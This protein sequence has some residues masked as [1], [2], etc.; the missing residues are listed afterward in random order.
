MGYGT[1]PLSPKYKDLFTG[2]SGTPEERYSAMLTAMGFTGAFNDQL[3]NFLHEMGYTGSLEDK[4]AQYE[5][6]PTRT[7]RYF[8]R[9]PC[10]LRLHFAHPDF[11]LPSWLT[12]SRGTHAMETDADGVLV[13]APHNMM[14]DSERASGAGG[15]ASID[16]DALLCPDGTVSATAFISDATTDTHFTNYGDSPNLYVA[17]KIHVYSAHLFAG[18]QD[19]VRFQPQ[20]WSAGY[21]AGTGH[22]FCYF[23]MANGTVGTNDEGGGMHYVDAQIEAVGG[24]PGWYRAQLMFSIDAGTDLTLHRVQ[25]IAA[26]AD[27]DVTFSGD[28]ATPTFYWWGEQMTRGRSTFDPLITTTGSAYYGPRLN[29]YD[30][31]DGTSLGYLGEEARTNL[32]L[33]SEDLDTTW[34]ESNGTVTANAGAAIDGNTTADD[35][36]HTSTAGEINQNITATDNTVHCIS[37]FVHQGT[38]GSHDWVKLIWKESTGNSGCQAYFDIST[39]AIG[40]SEALDTGTLTDVGII[41][42]GGGW[43][44]IWVSGQMVSGQTD[45]RVRMI[46]VISDDTTTSETTNSVWWW[47]IQVEV[48]SFPTSYIPTTTASATRNADVLSTTSMGWFNN[49]K[50]TV[51]TNYTVAAVLGADNV[52]VTWN[53]DDG[54]TADRW[55]H[56][57][58]NHAGNQDRVSFPSTAGGNGD[59]NSVAAMAANTSIRSAIGWAT[60][61]AAMSTNGSD[62]VADTDYDPPTDAMAV[63]EYGA[64]GFSNV[65]NI[66]VADWKYWSYRKP[67]TELEDMTAILPLATFDW[68]P[69]IDHSLTTRTPEFDADYTSAVTLTHSRGTHAMEYDS[70]GTLVYA[71]HNLAVQ[72]DDL[73]TSWAV[74]NNA[75]VTSSSR[76][77]YDGTENG[78]VRQFINLTADT[79]YTF[80]AEIKLASGTPLSDA[81]VQIFIY[82]N[83]AANSSQDIGSDIDDTWQTFSTTAT[84]DADGGLAVFAIRCDDVL[85]LDV[86]RVR[87]NA[88]PSDIGYNATTTAAYYGPR[89]NHYDP[90]T[91]TSLGYLGEEARTNLCLQ[92]EDFSTTWLNNFGGGV[93]LVTNQ[94][95]APDGNTTADQMNRID[96]NFDGVGHVTITVD[97]GSS[98]TMSV[99][100]KNIDANRSGMEWSSDLATDPKPRWDWTAGVPSIQSES[101]CDA[102][103]IQSIGDGWYRLSAS[104]TSDAV[105]TDGSF[106]VYPEHNGSGTEGAYMWGAMLEKGAF[107]TSYIPT[108]TAAVTRNADVLSTT[109][110][111][112]YDARQ[113]T[114]LWSGR[115]DATSGQGMF[116]FSLDDGTTDNRIQ[117]HWATGTDRA[118]DEVANGASKTVD[119]STAESYTPHVSSKYALAIASNDFAHVLDGGTVATDTALTIPPITTLI[120]NQRSATPSV[121]AGSIAFFTYWPIRRINDELVEITT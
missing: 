27:E 105:D 28:G 21:A 34:T 91:R 8:E 43:Y 60:D 47:G 81:S 117:T 99:F 66:T 31:V 3:Y 111:S 51:F 90:A 7:E 11:T 73:T 64:D 121:Q 119:S 76:V 120:L 101:G 38:T 44:R 18:D 55:T 10:D 107:P 16:V 83:V 115:P 82:N 54:T 102:T 89:L 106:V 88:G 69:A 52:E 29:H 80:T 72:S 20:A 4:L 26:E 92:S 74:N 23:D 116:V 37:A 12:H 58:R 87:V 68:Q 42:V 86:R 75:V 49:T 2:Y 103:F 77:T 100:V 30:P 57:K 40:T 15:G 114:L 46:N 45:G 84:A 104:F 50:G 63:L 19:W 56:Q 62:V 13:Y 22:V 71:P 113:G 118:R 59:I 97:T 36:I 98:Y 96:G 39:G 24:Y 33:Q 70:T 67:D 5:G 85:A 32:C 94:A 109:D 6:I 14:A 95:V 48:G 17:S 9:D 41:A 65:G 78:E 53:I 79:P 35:L 110:V 112:W 61:D 93:T 1:S 25:I 108:T